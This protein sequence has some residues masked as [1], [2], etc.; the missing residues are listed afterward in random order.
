MGHTRDIDRFHKYV[1]KTPS[2]WIWTGAKIP[3]GY[4]RFLFEGKPRYAH[5]VSLEIHGMGKVPD[6]KVVMHS[7]DNPSCVNPLHL[8]VGTPTDNMRDASTKGRIVNL[9]DWRGTRNPQ[10][11]LSEEQRMS[12]EAYLRAGSSCRELGAAF[13]VTK[14][15]VWQI[16]R[17]MKSKQGWEEEAF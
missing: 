12:L 6:D 8:S 15:R 5:R 9:Q 14:E 17:D 1:N 16:K 4:G 2:C 10:A 11:K 7:C 13:G 3:K